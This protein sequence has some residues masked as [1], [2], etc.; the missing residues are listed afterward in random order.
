MFIIGDLPFF[1]LKKIYLEGR[2]LL[3]SESLRGSVFFKPEKTLGFSKLFLKYFSSSF[4]YDRKIFKMLGICAWVYI[5]NKIAVCFLNCF[6][7]KDFTFYTLS[8]PSFGILKINLCTWDTCGSVLWPQ[9]SADGHAL[10]E[11]RRMWLDTHLGQRQQLVIPG[12]R[13]THGRGDQRERCGSW[14]Y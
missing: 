3:L 14:G 4:Y 12:W 13:D 8:R 11:P 2:G 6:S 10:W 7:I 9:A 5:S 1:F